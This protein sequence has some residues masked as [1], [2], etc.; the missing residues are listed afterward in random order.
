[1]RLSLSANRVLF[2]YIVDTC[3]IMGQARVITTTR[4]WKEQG[5]S[6]SQLETK[7]RESNCVV[8]EQAKSLF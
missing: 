4:D 8:V 5:S 2:V 1:M 7:G 6:T 3:H